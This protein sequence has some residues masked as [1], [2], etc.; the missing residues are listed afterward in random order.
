MIH[1][2]TGQPLLPQSA[3]DDLQAAE[4]MLLKAVPIIEAAKE[5]GIDVAM[6]D[7]A[8]KDYMDK[9]AKL[10]HYFGTS[11]VKHTLSG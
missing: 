4:D 3:L 1:P 5:C 6:H 8:Q 9:I 7:S 2:L 11:T 10:K